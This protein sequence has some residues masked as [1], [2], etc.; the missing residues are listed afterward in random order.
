[1]KWVE[2]KRGGTFVYKAGSLQLLSMTHVLYNG[3]LNPSRAR[4]MGMNAYSGR[5][6]P[7]ILLL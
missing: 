5:N 1:M 7:I 2:M 6:A 4:S 3:P